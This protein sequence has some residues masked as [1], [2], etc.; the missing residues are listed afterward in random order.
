ME[1]VLNSPTNSRNPADVAFGLPENQAQQENSKPKNESN[2]DIK[3]TNNFSNE[4][5]KATRKLRDSIIGILKEL[6]V[7]VG[8]LERFE[9][10]IGGAAITGLFDPDATKRTANG[11]LELIRVAQGEA[12]E[13]ALPEEFAHLLDMI[14]SDKSNPLYNRLT[15]LI[16]GSPELVEQILNEEEGGFE[17]YNNLYGG[18]TIR[19]AAEART[20]L[21]ARHL[22]NN[23]SI[24]K[25][26]EITR[27]L[28]S[29]ILQ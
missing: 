9:E 8:T 15:N 16:N 7:G 28:L 12:G 21:I 19:L 18:D 3:S 25:A 10:F 24:S 11:L 1:K 27:S 29:R 6:G 17:R 22:V 13:Q 14:L 2:S 26:P 23:Q 5:V 20:K 4:E